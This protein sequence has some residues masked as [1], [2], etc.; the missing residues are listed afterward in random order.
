MAA[1]T[2]AMAAAAR[3]TAAA[4]RARARAAAEVGSGAEARAVTVVAAAIV[5]V[6][7]AAEAAETRALVP[8]PTAR[9]VGLASRDQARRAEAEVKAVTAKEVALLV[10]HPTSNTVGT[11][12]CDRSRFGLCRR[13]YRRSMIAWTLVLLYLLAKNKFECTALDVLPASRPRRPGRPATKE[14]NER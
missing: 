14:P 3:T 13:G 9:K 12:S 8:R 5:A 6:A 2:R 10:P 1:A 11:A 4:V 7:E